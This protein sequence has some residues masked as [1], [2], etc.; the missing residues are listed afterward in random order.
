MQCLT[1]QSPRYERVHFGLRIVMILGTIVAAICK[2]ALTIFEHMRQ[3]WQYQYPWLQRQIEEETLRISIRIS[4]EHQILSLNLTLTR[5]IN[6]EKTNIC[7]RAMH[8]ISGL[9][10]SGT[11][12]SRGSSTWSWGSNW[13]SRRGYGTACK[14]GLHSTSKTCPGKICLCQPKAIPK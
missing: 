4:S 5:W 3:E 1:I 10:P 2:L 9:Q 13:S 12:P 8:R 14:A 11:I 6:H 7:S